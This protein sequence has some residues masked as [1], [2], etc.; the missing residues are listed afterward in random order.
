[1]LL[2]EKQTRDQKYC[3]TVPF[4]NQ[5]FRRRGLCPGHLSDHA[6]RPPLPHRHPRHGLLDR[7]CSGQAQ[8]MTCSYSKHSIHN[9]DDKHSKV[10]VLCKN[11]NRPSH[12]PS[13]PLSHAGL[14]IRSSFDR[15]RI[16]QIRIWKTGPGPESYL[17][18]CIRKAVKQFHGTQRSTDIFMLFFSWKK[19]NIFPENLEKVNFF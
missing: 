16:L 18:Y 13:L 19:F 12:I 3:K 10:N 5:L 9:K 15:I 2:D 4:N 8:R 14:R 1:M 11:W 7:L 6:Q 17:P